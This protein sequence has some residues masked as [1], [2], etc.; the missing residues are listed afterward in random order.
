[1]RKTF[2]IGIGATAALV[3]AAAAMAAVYTATGVS[4]TTATLTTT[5]ATDVKTRTCTGSDGKSFAVTE[6]QFSN[7]SATAADFIN[8][9]TDLD[10]PL[11]IHARLTMDTG[12]HLGFVDGSVRIKDGD[13][14]ITG[15][16]AGFLTANSAGNHAR[17]LGVVSGTYT[18]ATGFA[19]NLGSAPTGNLGVIAGP[20]CKNEKPKPT[21]PAAKPKRVEAEGTL[22][23][24]SPSLGI[25]TVTGKGSKTTTCTLGSVSTVGLVNGD[26]VELTCEYNTATS[27]WMVKELKKHQ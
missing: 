19:L 10:G 17:V 13:T 5:T 20:V 21:P 26:K 23:L 6:G 15:K 4:A 3:A 7:T 9:A 11:A 12:S 25:V 24:N 27:L 8:P 18:P 22:A 2:L 16:V 14:T 1:M